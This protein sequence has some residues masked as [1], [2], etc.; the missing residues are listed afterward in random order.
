MYSS[1]GEPFTAGESMIAQDGETVVYVE[2]VSNS[3]LLLW[4]NPFIWG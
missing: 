3:K 4:E 1:E 2:R